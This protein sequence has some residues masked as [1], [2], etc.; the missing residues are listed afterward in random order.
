MKNNNVWYLDVASSF[1]I[2]EASDIALDELGSS[3]L[4]YWNLSAD[5]GE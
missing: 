5:T 2:D 1:T 4:D 3:E